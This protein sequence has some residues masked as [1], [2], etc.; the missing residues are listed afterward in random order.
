MKILLVADISGWAIDQLAK[1]KVKYNPHHDIKLVYVHPRDAG[2]VAKQIEFE[3]TVRDFKPDII[4]FEYYRSCSQLL[5]ALPFLKDYKII[6][7]HHNQ[8]DKAIYEKDWNKIGVN[9]LTT[10]T[11]KAAMMLVE[12]GQ[13]NV[14]VIK[15][16]IDLEEFNYSDKEPEEFTVGYA[17]RVVPWKGL[18]D[19]AEVALELGIKV[20]FMG[21]MEKA[22]YWASISEDARQN[23]DF[24]FLDCKDEDR[25]NFYRSLSCYIGNSRDGLEEGTLEYLEAMA[26]GV[27][28]ITTPSGSA[29][30]HGKDGENCIMIDF[31]NRDQLKEAMI[32][33]RDDKDLRN[34]LRK[35]GW[36]TVKNYPG[37]RMAYDFSKLYYEVYNEEFPLVSVI[38]PATY[39]RINEINDILTSLDEQSYPNLEA[40][41]VWDEVE[42]KETNFM[43]RD[44]SIK[45]LYT[46][47]EG[48]NLA[49][50]R[51]MGAVEAEGEIL[52]FC[53]SR[54]KPEPDA[55]MMFQ[56]AILHASEITMGGNKKIWYFGDKGGAKKA[57]VENFS[58][59]RREYFMEFGMMNERVLEYGGA[60]QEIRTRWI[61][62]GGQTSYLPVAKAKEIKGS[63]LTNERRKSIINMKFLL[64]KMY[65]SQRY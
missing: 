49:M 35:N 63:K 8:K 53:D 60:S 34:K 31:E 57:F 22:D 18:K 30:D 5:E 23:I 52:M 38:V 20:K 16:G 7:T 64:Y 54:L 39:D 40:V 48:Y 37:E 65:N 44:I 41:V 42:E 61:K 21:R 4:H 47:K 58:A 2:S 12:R 13:K 17:G 62:Q 29:R 32:K 26:T 25:I 45:Q 36:N 15:H 3:K 46:K 19:I 50:A 14:H 28:V 56:Q 55:V 24:E 43:G 33:M 1:V 6:L 51:N 27:P 59:L 10:F 9:H 11:E